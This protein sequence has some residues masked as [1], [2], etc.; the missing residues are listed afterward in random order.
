VALGFRLSAAGFVFR[1]CD[2]SLGLAPLDRLFHVGNPT[3]SVGYMGCNLRSGEA[4][5]NSITYRLSPLLAVGDVTVL[6]R[7]SVL[8]HTFGCPDRPRR[9]RKVSGGCC[10]RRRELPGQSKIKKTVCGLRTIGLRTIKPRAGRNWPT[11]A[12][13]LRQKDFVLPAFVR[14]LDGFAVLPDYPTWNTS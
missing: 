8:I 6:T 11:K 5:S 12:L 1:L 2:T 7:N 3:R 9:A 14:P 13:N 10:Y 4:I